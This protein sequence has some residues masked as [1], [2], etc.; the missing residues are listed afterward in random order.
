MMETIGMVFG[1]VGVSPDGIPA[2]HDVRDFPLYKEMYRVVARFKSA[3]GNMIVDST[4]ADVTS[5]A[6]DHS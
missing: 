2:V 6:I 4:N 5:N 3:C 1:E